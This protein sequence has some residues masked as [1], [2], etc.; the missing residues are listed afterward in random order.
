[1][2]EWKQLKQKV[3]AVNLKNIIPNCEHEYC[4]KVL[5][6]GAIEQCPKFDECTKFDFAKNLA[7]NFY[8]ADLGESLL[9]KSRL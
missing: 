2:T 6:G 8:E 7:L 5:L 1:M 9:N 4:R 3:R